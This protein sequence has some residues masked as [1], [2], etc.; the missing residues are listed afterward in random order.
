MRN[1]GDDLVVKLVRVG[2]DFIF[3]WT[4]SLGNRPAVNVMSAIKSKH[5]EA[6]S[7]EI[8]YVVMQDD[9]AH[10]L[11]FHTVHVILT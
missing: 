2:T 8:I 5:I 10:L 6:G 9:V 11:K 4:M 1:K 7:I 3:R